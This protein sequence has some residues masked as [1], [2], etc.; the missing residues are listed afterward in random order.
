[1][2]GA[3]LSFDAF[4]CAEDTQCDRE[5]LGVCQAGSCTYPDPS[6]P[7]G[8]IYDDNAEGDLAGQCVFV[9]GTGTG[10]GG[11]SGVG[12]DGS[13]GTGTDGGDT[14]SVDDSTGAT[15]AAESGDS[16]GGS[17]CGG[18]GAACCP[19]S[20]CD[21][22]LACLGDGCSCVQS[23]VAGDRHTCVVKL[24][25][26]VHCWGDNQFGQIGQAMLTP[27]TTPVEVVGPFAAGTPATLVSARNHTCAQ[28]DDGTVY[29]WGDNSTG[30]VNPAS[31]V[32]AVTD[33]TLAAW[34]TGTTG[35]V[36]AGG[37]H[38]CSARGIAAATTCWGDNT[39]GQLTSAA[40]GP[41]PVNNVSGVEYSQVVAGD[42]F[43]CGAQ[44]TGAVQ[45]WGNNA[46]SQLANAGAGATSNTPVAASVGNAAALVA[47][48]QHA[49]AQ[50]GSGVQCWGRGNLG[51]LGNGMNLNSAV[52]VV[53]SLPVGAV[54][55]QIASGPNHT[56]VV[57]AVGEVYCW[58]SNNNGQIAPS[59]NKKVDEF[60]LTP[61]LLDIG[62][63][64]VQIATGETHTC[65]LST[66]GEVLC[67]G[68][69]SEGQLGDGTT[70]YGFEPTPAM[71]TC[72]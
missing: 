42:D 70:N 59:F 53:V 50:V 55:A 14:L 19:G 21:A 64:A 62:V 31:G 61:V 72:P 27:S 5:M 18:A 25:G 1:M 4:T 48:S 52:G 22:G 10:T 37:G 24:D 54:P 45:C 68:T 32:L 9:D 33:P 3:C 49:C 15:D 34:A 44:L 39:S 60:T 35:G 30:Q 46:Q 2:L 67:W 8:Y 23:L 11:P 71:L 66:G 6:C 57:T 29:C 65:V 17:E 7:S 36:A 63:T 13:T 20:T 69:N 41:T 58:G 28:R 16:T 38:T 47:G 51:Q 56:C 40:V 43:S 26:T 12:T